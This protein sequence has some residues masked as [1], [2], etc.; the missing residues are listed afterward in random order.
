MSNLAAAPSEQ[1][2]PKRTARPFQLRLRTREAI[3]A[4]LF[5]LPFLIF[6]TVFV[7]RA[8]V[9]AVN[10]SFYE[11]PI[12]AKTHKFIGLGNYEELFNDDVWWLSLKNTI[13]FALLTVAGTSSIA[14]GAA[15]AINQPIRAKSFFRILLY[16][17]SL[18]S[19]GVVG[20]TWVWL[21][22]TQFGIINYGLSLFG[23]RQIN[24]LGD[25]NLV[26]PAL[27]I[28]TVW[29][30]FG[31]PMLI[32]LAGLQGIPEQFYEAARIDGANSRQLFSYITL[33]LLRP[34]ILFV[35]VTGIISHLQLF[36]QNFI[37]TSGG[38]GRASYSVILYL[39]QIAWRSFRMGYGA[40]VAVSLAFIMMIL[41]L[42][43]F[44]FINRRVDY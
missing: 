28:T 25:T 39:Y 17:P 32:F 23:V 22:N 42:I 40:A 38:P 5:L 19:V 6:F 33:P 11:W 21:L 36:G 26:L 1:V 7:L 43:Q 41:T 13:V 8:I 27:S 2:I 10:M 30:T 35:T 9:T 31:F 14:L 16:A 15:L 4:Y 29:W 24:W 12:L 3:A 37:M 34:T 44:A 18:L 20:S